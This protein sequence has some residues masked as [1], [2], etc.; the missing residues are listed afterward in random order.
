[1]SL[2]N[3][4]NVNFR[5]PKSLL[6]DNIYGKVFVSFVIEN[7]GTT[8]THKVIRGVHPILDKEA[9]R[10]AKLIKFET[11]GMQ[12]G[13]KVRVSYCLPITVTLPE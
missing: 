5:Y 1:D 13:K 12:S 11:P 3:F 8:S 10:V 2:T 9:L 4:I 7:D 6:E